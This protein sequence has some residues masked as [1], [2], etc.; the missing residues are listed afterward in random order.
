[1]NTKGVPRIGRRMVRT[2]TTIL[3]VNPHSNTGG[4][5]CPPIEETKAQREEN[6]YLGSHSK[7]AAEVAFEPRAVPQQGLERTCSEALPEGCA[8]SLLRTCTPAP[9]LAQGSPRR[10]RQLTRH[11]GQK[12]VEQHHPC[13]VEHGADLEGGGQSQ[14]LGKRG[15]AHP[16][17]TPTR[18]YPP[19]A[20]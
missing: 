5:H 1:M 7:S 15:C 2:L 16:D 6:P 17:P 4:R 12:G 19:P 8:P 10:Q 13:V 3:L 14:G 9:G 20:D 18:L 11:G